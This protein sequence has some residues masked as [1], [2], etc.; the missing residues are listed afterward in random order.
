[1][2]KHPLI[3]VELPDERWAFVLAQKI[4]DRTGLTIVMT[5]EDGDEVCSVT[6]DRKHLN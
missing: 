1:V 2:S 5:D 3:S 4:A 6:P